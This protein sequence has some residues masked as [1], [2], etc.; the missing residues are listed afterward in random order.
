MN[1]IPELPMDKEEIK[2]WI[3][4]RDPFLLVDKVTKVSKGE[5][6]IAGRTLTGKEDVFKGHFPGQPV[7]PGVLIVESLAQTGAMLGVLS[8]GEK[9]GCLLTEIQSARFKKT[10]LPPCEVTYKVTLKK[11]R[12]GFLWFEGEAFVEDDLAA[13]VSYSARMT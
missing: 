2:K 7:Y 1:D 9:R 12:A 11:Q 8:M 10:V 13:T 3:P 5:S 6:I 4:H